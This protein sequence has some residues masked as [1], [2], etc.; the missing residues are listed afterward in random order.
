MNKCIGNIEKQDCIK[1]QESHITN[2]KE[3]TERLESIINQKDQINKELLKNNETLK[4]DTS[5]DLQLKTKDD[6]I[7][8]LKKDNENLNFQLDNINKQIKPKDQ[9]LKTKILENDINLKEI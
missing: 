3:K 1:G 6:V 5:K 9:I 8:N 7:V 2:L 4:N